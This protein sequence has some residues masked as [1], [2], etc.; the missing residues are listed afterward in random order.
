[1]DGYQFAQA[2]INCERSLTFNFLKP[3]QVLKVLYIDTLVVLP[4]AIY[5][6]LA[7]LCK[8]T[9]IF[10]MH[11]SDYTGIDIWCY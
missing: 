3:L 9:G 7:S 6:M 8:Q 2:K 4:M 1:M 5:L 11:Y 10:K